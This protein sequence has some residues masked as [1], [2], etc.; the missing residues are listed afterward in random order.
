MAA[1]AT[2]VTR[3]YVNLTAVVA[4]NLTRGLKLDG[5]GGGLM[6]CSLVLLNYDNMLHVIRRIRCL[7][8][9]TA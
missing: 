2:N 8:W 1:A 3:G 9:S 7:W 6:L 4:T 5:G